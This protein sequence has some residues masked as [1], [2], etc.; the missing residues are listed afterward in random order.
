MRLTVN[1]QLLTL[2]FHQHFFGFGDRLRRI[3]SLGAGF[4]AIHDGVAAV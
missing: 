4:G 2:A 3:Q 1:G